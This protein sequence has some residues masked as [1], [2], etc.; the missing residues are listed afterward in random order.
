MVTLVFSTGDEYSVSGPTTLHAAAQH[1]LEEED[2]AGE[3]R[4]ILDVIDAVGNAAEE[5]RNGSAYTVLVNGGEMSPGARL[6]RSGA[7]TVAVRRQ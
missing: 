5:K 6:P 7:V 4:F 1:I 3:T 2:P